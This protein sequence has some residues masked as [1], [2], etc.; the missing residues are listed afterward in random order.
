MFTCLYTIYIRK[1]NFEHIFLK[2]L[3]NIY[4]S[5]LVNLLNPIYGP[6][7]GQFLLTVI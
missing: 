5:C 4:N 7:W 1:K 2:I 3:K 6:S